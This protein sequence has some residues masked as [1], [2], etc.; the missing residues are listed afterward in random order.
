MVPWQ[1]LPSYLPLSTRLDSDSV[2]LAPTGI[3]YV[4]FWVTASVITTGCSV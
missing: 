2:L 3:V 4:T 1:G